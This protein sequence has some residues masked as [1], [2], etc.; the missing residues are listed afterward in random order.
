[1]LH[2]NQWP[3]EPQSG[4]HCTE[5]QRITLWLWKDDWKQS[6]CTKSSETH[7]SPENFEIN[8]AIITVYTKHFGTELNATMCRLK[9]SRFKWHCG[10]HDH[11]SVDAERNT[12]TSDFDLSI[13]QCRRA[14]KE[15]KTQ[16]L[17]YMVQFKKETKLVQSYT[18]G[19]KAKK[20]ETIAMEGLGW[21]KTLLKATSKRW[22]YQLNWEIEQYIM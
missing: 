17:D 18:N 6:I 10:Y 11:A 5:I 4:R 12:I 20:I 16:I 2:P 9:H 19:R 3:S 15:E 21:L 8:P 14:W 1:M 7:V 13:E 22:L